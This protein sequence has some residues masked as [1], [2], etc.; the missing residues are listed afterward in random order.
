ML[1]KDLDEVPSGQ[2][3]EVELLIESKNDY[4]YLLLEDNKSRV[5]GSGGHAE[6]V[7]LLG[8]IADLS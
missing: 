6:R 8:R 1:L 5:L 2:L 4:E 7:F 3:V